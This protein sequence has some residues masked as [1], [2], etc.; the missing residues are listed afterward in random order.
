M[1]YVKDYLRETSNNVVMLAW[2]KTGGVGILIGVGL[3]VGVLLSM[4]IFI[5]FLEKQPIV[6]PVQISAVPN[7]RATT[8]GKKENSAT[9]ATTPAQQAHETKIPPTNVTAK[10]A[11]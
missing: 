1:D 3:M 2:R 5:L 4:L 7:N 10:K 6:H 8:G 11:E 9:S